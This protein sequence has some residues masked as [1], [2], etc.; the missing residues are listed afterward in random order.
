MYSTPNAV[1][2]ATSAER[3]SVIDRLARKYTVAESLASLCDLADGYCP[4][5]YGGVKR[6]TRALADAYD[7]YQARRGDPRR[8]FRG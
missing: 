8:A 7:R 1:A 3:R 2:N 4:S 5:I 6:E